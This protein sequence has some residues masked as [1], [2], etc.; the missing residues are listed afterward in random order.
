MTSY[1]VTCITKTPDK[2][3]YL[4][5]FVSYFSNKTYGVG[6]LKNRFD[7]SFE[8]TKQMLRLPGKNIIAK[9]YVH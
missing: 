9:G 4:V 6:T 5:G 2:S 8:H 3:A 1:W 7:D